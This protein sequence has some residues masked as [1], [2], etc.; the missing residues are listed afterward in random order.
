[1][2][3]I[4]LI[5]ISQIVARQRG[6]AMPSDPQITWIE[7]LAQ[8][9]LQ[10]KHLLNQLAPAQWQTQIYSEGAKWTVADIIAH[11]IDSERGMSIHIHRIRQG[12]P[13]IPAEFDLEQW[14]RQL[15][16][17]YPERKPGELQ[18]AL[19][20]TRTRTLAE[21]RQL[22]PEDWAKT[23]RHPARGQISIAQYYETIHLHEILHT[24]DIR[25][26]LNL[27]E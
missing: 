27:A 5:L 8:S 1:M 21:M 13:T 26:A 14:N 2:P 24:T 15:E 7:K 9:R 25:Q 23:G 17:R 12:K 3:A 11:L 19:A 20:E 10:L 18:L 22:A 4:N 16:S 6:N